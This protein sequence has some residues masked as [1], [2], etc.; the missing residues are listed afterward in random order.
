MFRGRSR[1]YR[2]RVHV[3]QKMVK[4]C[5]FGGFTG[6]AA[7]TESAS[8]AQTVEHLELGLDRCLGKE[9]KTGKD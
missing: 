9:K 3:G 2:L 4:R 1:W 5:E 8:P 7:Q 6:A